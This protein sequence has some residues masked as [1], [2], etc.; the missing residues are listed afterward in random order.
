MFILPQ[1]KRKQGLENGTE[2][3]Q[4]KNENGQT[5][6]LLEGLPRVVTPSLS[7]SAKTLNPETLQAQ[8]SLLR[9]V[10]Y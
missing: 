8:G 1:Q 4:I 2:R 5:R 9:R 6:Q 10:I 3:A 7:I